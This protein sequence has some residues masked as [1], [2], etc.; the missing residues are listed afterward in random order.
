MKREA[1]YIAKFELK[2][3]EEEEKNVPKKDFFYSSY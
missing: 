2:C 1:S 3:V